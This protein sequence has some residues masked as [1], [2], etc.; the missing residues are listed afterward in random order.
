MKRPLDVFWSRTLRQFFCISFGIKD[1]LHCHNYCLRRLNYQEMTVDIKLLERSGCEVTG[2]EVQHLPERL[3]ARSYG[4]SEAG[5][6]LLLGPGSISIRGVAQRN[7]DEWANEI[8]GFDSNLIF[9]A[10]TAE[11]MAWPLWPYQPIWLLWDMSQNSQKA[12]IT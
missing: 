12:I 10:F 2:Y 5:F 3:L 11:S 1:V 4:R 9:S 7:S 6:Q 8:S